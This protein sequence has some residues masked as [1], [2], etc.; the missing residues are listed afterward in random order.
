[1]RR[2]KYEDLIVQVEE[3][4]HF[5]FIYALY[6]LSQQKKLPPAGARGATLGIMTA[7]EMWISM[8]SGNDFSDSPL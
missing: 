6:L 4:T 1:M 5:S 3:I 2:Q 7:S 8:D